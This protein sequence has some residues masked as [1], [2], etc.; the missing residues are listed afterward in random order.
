MMEFINHI[1][2]ASG[3]DA[4]IYSYTDLGTAQK[5]ESFF[6]SMKQRADRTKVWVWD[7]DTLRR[8]MFVQLLRY[9]ITDT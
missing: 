4:G 7:T 8:R 3:I 5:I 2:T 1:G 9:A 6:E